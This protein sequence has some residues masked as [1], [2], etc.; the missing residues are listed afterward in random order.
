M[1][2]KTLLSL[3][4]LATIFVVLVPPI[5]A[6]PTVLYLDPALI[7]EP[8]Y[9]ICNSFNVTMRVDA[10]VNLLL[11]AVDITWDPAVLEL[12][13]GDLAGFEFPGGSGIY[14]N[15]WEGAIFPT[16]TGFVAVSIDN[17]GLGLVDGVY[18][19]TCGK[20]PPGVNVP[21]RPNDLAKLE[22]HIK[23]ACPPPLYD[24]YINIGPTDVLADASAHQIPHTTET[25][26][27]H[28]SPPPP[29]SPDAI[30]TP[31]NCHLFY[32]GD[33]IP[34]VGT[35]STQGFD[36]EACPITIYMWEID[37][38]NDGS[39]EIT[40]FG[41][42]TNTYTC[43]A[44]GDV[45][46]TLTVTAPGIPPT[47]PRYG[48]TIPDHD[49]EKHVIHQVT[50]PTGPAIDVYTESGG[51]GPG[52]D[53]GGVAWPYPTD[54]SDAF[55]PQEE[56][57]VYAKVTWND[58]PVQNKPVAF[59]VKDENMEP[60]LYRTAF[61][62]ENGIATIDYRMVWECS[63][64][65]EFVGNYEVWTIYATVS[66]SEQ[67]V[68]DIVKY[69]YG[70]LVQ[71]EQVDVD[72]T[73]AIKCTWVTITVNLKNI[74]M[75]D[76]TVF[77]TVV[78]YDDCGV[79]IGLDS[80]TVTVPHDNPFWDPEFSIHIVKWTYLG[81]GTIYA[82]V[83]TQAPQLGGVPMCPEKSTTIILAKAP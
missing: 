24:S 35:A 58:E 1:N 52:R 4:M 41:M 6:S 2:R 27:I 53:E 32:V 75:L 62:D 9:G 64:S 47:D 63:R 39:I 76:Q 66:V 80:T 34:L 7:S 49:S 57:T 16:S 28:V 69:R 37:E 83:Y 56:I 26:R 10:V 65:P 68:S 48:D 40:L 50:K 33:V 13:T 61:T 5:Q 74:G 21:P 8:E 30:F 12:K 60:V 42:D 20:I 59:E 81:Q 73:T 82:N 14:Y 18:G 17:D 43:H 3:V 77:V 51:T 55:A 23:G 22:F 11:W 79:P 44:P 67:I 36:P 25:T 19:L 71:I 45:G 78:L 72:P 29:T 46:I 70:W 15:I 31:L 38:G 54:W